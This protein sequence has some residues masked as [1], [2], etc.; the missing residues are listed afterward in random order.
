LGYG[1]GSGTLSGPWNQPVFVDLM[2]ADGDPIPASAVPQIEPIPGMTVDWS[3]FVTE[4]GKQLMT[5]GHHWPL[6][7]PLNNKERANAEREGVC[8]ACHQEI[9]NESLAISLL[10]HVAKRIDALPKNNQQHTDLIH[11]NILLSA[12]VQAAGMILGPLCVLGVAWLGWRRF[13]NR[14]RNKPDEANSS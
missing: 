13:R 11:K 6:S 10:H 7:R 9:P 2:T 5:V 14:R 8:L 3:R 1:I 4:D 12:W